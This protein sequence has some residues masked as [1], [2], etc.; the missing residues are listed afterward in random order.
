MIERAAYAKRGGE[1]P[2]SLRGD[3]PTV[4]RS[5]GILAP[6]VGGRRVYELRPDACVIYLV[7]HGFTAF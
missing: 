4:E 5:P 1:K 3:C 2:P 6:L 7:R